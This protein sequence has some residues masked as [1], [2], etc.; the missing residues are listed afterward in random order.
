[1]KILLL[2]GSNTG[3]WEGWAHHFV[4]LA[5]RVLEA[6]ITN[7]FLGA[8]GSLYGLMQLLK[9]E[10]EGGVHPEIVIFEYMLNDI[11]LVSQNAISPILIR[12]TLEDISEYCLD[13]KIILQFL[14]LTPRRHRRL[15]AL[16]S[17]RL[18]TTTYNKLARDYGFPKPLLQDEVLGRRIFDKD[19]L[20][21]A[22]FRPEISRRIA[23]T[24]LARI[25]ALPK[26]APNRIAPRRRRAFE[27]VDASQ[28]EASGRACQTKLEMTVLKGPLVEM[29]RP[30]ITIWPATGRLVGV[31]FRSR[32]T[33]GWYR[34][35]VG[36]T[37]RRKNACVTDLLLLAELIAM[38]YPNIRAK[39]CGSIEIAMPEDEA[40]LMRL[41]H[42][43][44]PMELSPR[45]P[46]GEQDLAIHGLMLW[47]GPFG[48]ARL[49]EP[50]DF[51]RRLVLRGVLTGT[52]GITV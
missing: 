11:L 25:S 28:A 2:G 3:I 12:D 51:W 42:D 37:Q 50:F 7:G 23:E 45:R 6:N 33:S 46:F 20:D 9:H 27:Y 36:H 13:R 38:Q 24:L 17:S 29:N 35:T 40:E 31:V 10:R 18:V 16:S 48:F 15:I 21:E 41:A 52:L 43:V 19:Y 49:F 34:L 30:A 1:L 14:C 8:V 47:R 22:H 5:E 4:A 26:E 44:S 32:P 39:A